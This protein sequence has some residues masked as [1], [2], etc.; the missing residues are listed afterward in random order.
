MKKILFIL[1]FISSA[2]FAQF[3]EP[4]Q[5]KGL[6]LDIAVGPRF[7]IGTFS[8]N[9]NLGVGAD[10]TISYTDNKLLPVFFYGRIGYQHYPGSQDFYKTTNH[11]SFSSNVLVI[12]SGIRYYFPPFI[13]DMVLL[14]PVLEGGISFGYFEQAHIFKLGSGIN[15]F[16]EE[17]SKFGAHIG[18][19]FSMFLLDVMINYNYFELNQYISADIKIRI[20][21]YAII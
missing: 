7:P 9:S 3:F 20:P 12:N 6:F 5:A 15:N 13:K 21:I 8:D 19:G 18:G 10:I 4:G 17:L 14:M 16:T 2:N 11:A 1:F